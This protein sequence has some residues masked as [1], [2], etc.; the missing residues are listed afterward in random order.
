M[1]LT[2]YCEL[3]AAEVVLKIEDPAKKLRN[4]LVVVIKDIDLDPTNS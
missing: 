1:H 3:V 2:A 4:H